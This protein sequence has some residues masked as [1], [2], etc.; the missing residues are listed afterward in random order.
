MKITRVT[1]KKTRKQFLEAA[2]II[3]KND[4]VWVCP[5]DKEIEAI[6]DPE[7]NPY[8]KHGE[9]ERWILFDDDN[10]LMGRVAAFIDNNL[11]GSNDQPTGGMGFFE[12]INDRRYAFLL[13]TPCRVKKFHVQFPYF[14]VL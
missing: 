10:N 1:D 11:T 6:F 13:F 8:Y 5:L 12:C 7:K 2:K 14:R 9:A 4:K 3:Y